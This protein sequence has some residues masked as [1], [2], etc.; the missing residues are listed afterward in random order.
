MNRIVS[1]ATAWVFVVGTWAALPA[2]TYAEAKPAAL[3]PVPEKK[4]LEWSES[5]VK[6]IDS[7]EGAAELIDWKALMVRCA[8][9]VGASPEEIDEFR[10]GIE[11]A[12]AT[13]QGLLGMI[14]NEVKNGGGF[15]YIR[16]FKD[17]EGTRVKF[18]LLP[19][20]GGITFHDFLLKDEKGLVQAIDIRIASTGEDFSQSMRRFFVPSV[21]QKNKGILQK[22]AGKESAL[23]KSLGQLEEMTNAI[24]AN[25]PQ[26]VAA[27]AAKLPKEVR[28]EKFCMLIELKAAQMA[29][30]D[31]A[32]QEV[33]ERFRGL[34][35]NDSAVDLLSMDYFAIKE[36][37]KEALACAQRFQKA[38]GEEAFMTTLIADLQWQ[39]GQV[40][41]AR[42]TIEKAIKM[43]P[44]FVSARWTKVTIADAQQDYATLNKTLK[45]L[46]TDFGAELDPEAMKKEAF[47]EEF[48]KTPE[49][50]DL[51][52]FLKAQ[53]A[54]KK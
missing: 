2:M 10:M 35:P 3:A 11:Q 1:L 20:A 51:E 45:E 52:K 15:K 23:L 18:R 38:M 27:I 48:N 29:G 41:E 14:A 47:Y 49:F 30:D 5:L 28:N 25:E 8:R 32:H 6:A 36:N 43:E 26:K 24:Q 7:G 53:K 46:V 33:I 19:A 50:K 22:L 16:T 42:A 12:A 37:F 9:G 17:A 34:F 21:A 31:K 13:P 44:D 54:Q 4:A 40:K 39:N